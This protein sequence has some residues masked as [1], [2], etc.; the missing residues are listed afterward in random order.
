MATAAIDGG[1]ILQ[2]LAVYSDQPRYADMVLD[3]I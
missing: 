3:L 1:T 2:R